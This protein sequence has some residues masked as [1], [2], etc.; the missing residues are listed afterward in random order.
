MQAV[1]VLSAPVS[2]CSPVSTEE[3]P[4]I[5]VGGSGQ[6]NPVM[7]PMLALAII[8]RSFDNICPSAAPVMYTSARAFCSAVSVNVPMFARATIRTSL[9]MIEPSP[10]ASPHKANEGLQNPKHKNTIDKNDIFKNSISYLLAI[11]PLNE[12]I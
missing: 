3:L 7:L 9:L 8:S 4:H 1:F 10:L 2:H 11:V 6:C 12:C 5:G